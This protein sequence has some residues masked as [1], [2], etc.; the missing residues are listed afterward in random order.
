MNIELRKTPYYLINCAQFEKNCL[1]IEN[2]FKENWG[3]N[4]LFGYS[5][6]TNSH[7]ML[8]RMA[9]NRG[10]LAEVVSNDE[11]MYVTDLEGR[12]QEMI[13]NGPIKGDMIRHAMNQN[14]FLNLDHL[15]EVEKICQL[16]KNGKYKAEDLK[17]GLRINFDLESLCPGE[18]TAGENVI[19]FGINYENGDVGK[20]VR[21][22]ENN[23]I[24]IVGLHMHTS[25]K[26]RSLEVFKRISNMVCNIVEEYKLN[27]KYIDIGGGFFGG[28]I[29][30]GKPLMRE[31]AQVITKELKRKLEPSRVALI[32]E[33][34]A[35]VV[36]TAVDYVTRIDNIRDIKGE[37]VVTLDGTVLHINP[38]MLQRKPVFDI[39][40]TGKN[41]VGIQHICG[42]TCMEKDRFDIL[43]DKKELLVGGELIF[44]NVGAYT[45]SFNSH[46]IVSPPKVY[47]K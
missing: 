13:C 7:P 26:T 42:C 41:K 20:A 31:Y 19:R 46:F 22:L 29:L 5:V 4:V 32:V 6:K 9:K 10:W 37:S 24:P 18:T 28:K 21:I 12:S 23:G 8:I 40:H 38:F 17:I 15:Q 11:F 14:Y 27:L 33:P 44:H 25:T 16:N 45:M 39:D 36:A 35:S 30:A 2:S 34:G 3:E 43:Y 1:D 47:I